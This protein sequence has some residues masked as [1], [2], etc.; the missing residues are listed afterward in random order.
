MGSIISD[1]VIAKN[2]HRIP[3]VESQRIDEIS[4]AVARAKTA[5]EACVKRLEPE[6]LARIYESSASTLSEARAT[7]QA[8]HGH[9]D[10][11][12]RAMAEIA[13]RQSE[14][15]L[16]D[17][18]AMREIFR[19][20]FREVLA[21]DMQTGLYRLVEETEYCQSRPLLPPCHF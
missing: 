13:A 5:L 10:I 20:C 3:A 7:R 11:M 6:R 16:Q 21:S 18:K 17:G 9:H 2:V 15:L 19:E 12:M 14:S 8:V 4:N 1:L